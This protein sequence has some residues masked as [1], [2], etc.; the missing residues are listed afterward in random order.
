MFNLKQYMDYVDDDKEA[1]FFDPWDSVFETLGGVKVM[2]CSSS[3]W[4]YG[5]SIDI[6]ILLSDGRILSY[7]YAFDS[8]CDRLEGTCDDEGQKEIEDDI[9]QHATYFDDLAQYNAWV[10]TLPGDGWGE[11]KEENERKVFRK[12]HNMVGMV[13]W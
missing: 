8:C 7:S 10:D 4:G 5:G 3:Y 13:K 12:K 11:F 2:F 1:E 9:K 6:D